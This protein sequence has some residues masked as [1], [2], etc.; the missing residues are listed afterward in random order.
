MAT[1]C[2]ALI[3]A[4]N[5]NAQQIT[6]DPAITRMMQ[7][8][9]EFNQA[10]Q[11]VRGWRVQILVTS[12]RRQMERVRSR[13]VRLHPEYELH[14]THENPYYHLKTGA[15]LTQHSARPVLHKLRRDFPGAFLVAGEIALE[16]VLL[17]Q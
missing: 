7:S 17:Y 2:I 15:F 4:L 16:E 1:S 5:I 13:F 10:H 14:F 6:E 8:F 9:V 12:D 3:L 11:A